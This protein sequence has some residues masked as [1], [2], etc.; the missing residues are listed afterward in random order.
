MQ[1]NINLLK[2]QVQQEIDNLMVEKPPQGHL[3][4]AIRAGMFEAFYRVLNLIE[5]LEEK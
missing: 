1:E 5:K 4:W 2:V 3:R